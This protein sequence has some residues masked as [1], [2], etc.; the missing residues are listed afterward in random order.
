MSLDLVG[1]KFGEAS[2]RCDATVVFKLSNRISLGVLSVL[3]DVVPIL[4]F[5]PARIELNE[6]AQGVGLRPSEKI[7]SVL[8]F[9]LYSR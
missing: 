9:W 7:C 1:L 6:R 4:F 5:C 3:T 8:A 2:E